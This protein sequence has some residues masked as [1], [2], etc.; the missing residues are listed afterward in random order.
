VAPAI[1]SH[2]VSVTINAGGSATLSVVATGT[3]LTY[4]WMN[5]AGAAIANATGA[6][7]TTG[8]AG[9]Y[10]VVV[11][12]DLGSVT[13]NPATVTVITPPVITT[14]PASATITEGNTHTFNV[15]ASGSNL[16][17]QWRSAQGPITG[18]TGSSYA[19]GT[20]GT[21][22]VVVSNSAGSVPSVNATLTVSPREVAPVITA[23]PASVTINAGGNATLSVIA[24]GTS[25]SYQWM[26]AAGA[27][28]ANATGAS[29][30]TGAAG[31]Y[32]V[33]VHNDLGSVTSNPATVTV[34]TPPVITT[35][36]TSVTINQGQTTTLSVVASGAPP[37]SYQWRLNDAP[38]TNANAAGYTTGVAGTY[39][40]TVS[41]GAGPTTSIN[42]TVTVIVPLS[43][44][45]TPTSATINQG[46]TATFRAV[47]TGTGAASVTFQWN[48]ARGP[49]TGATT[50]SFTTG[51]SGT[52]TVRVSN[53]AG[54]VTG[55]VTV[56]VITP[57]VITA[58]PQSAALPVGS[59]HT[60]S[61]KASGAGLQYQWFEIISKAPQ[62]IKGANNPDYTT[63]TSGTYFV[64]VRNTAGAV[65]SDYA[66]VRFNGGAPVITDIVQ[67]CGSTSCEWTVLA[68]GIT[69]IT[70]QWYM[71]FTGGREPIGGAT[72]P[73]YTASKPGSYVLDIHNPAG[74]ITSPVLT[75]PTPKV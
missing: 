46:Q 57:P 56:N 62:A 60:M 21:Y 32:R 6:S 22:S 58:Q 55:S 8:A 12:N 73:T 51:T 74:F 25:L 17:Y 68:T 26:N 61:V 71:L 39:S 34:I 28:I 11:R 15:I 70:Y 50:D 66:E 24:T 38:I 4:Q 9:T 14:Q 41:N 36:P 65:D 1:T 18:A 44:V 19:T 35:Q 37:L 13:S 16:A 45:I 29:Y 23:H 54:S 5:A 40:V 27:A 75:F 10:R 63:S 64:E 43:I 2:P 72:S 3:S 33:V 7:Y 69:P 30:T 31:T 20:A 53:S 52:Y 42:A 48:D 47:V 59:R 67:K 49:I